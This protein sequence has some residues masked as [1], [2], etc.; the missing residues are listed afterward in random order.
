M[1]YVFFVLMYFTAR[2]CFVNVT[3]LVAFIS[4]TDCTL[5]L[6][7]LQVDLANFEL[8]SSM[9]KEFAV[10]VSDRYP[11]REWTSLGTFTALDQK[12]VQSFKLQS[13]AYGKY[14][15]VSCDCWA[16]PILPRRQDPLLSPQ[17][18]ITSGFRQRCLA[19]I[20][21]AASMSRSVF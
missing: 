11:T 9:P 4:Y 3:F 21:I 6:S 13:E 2:L 12:A 20:G 1:F 5:L 17:N 7:L 19:C 18:I 14:I 15:K 16:G 10:S 8:F